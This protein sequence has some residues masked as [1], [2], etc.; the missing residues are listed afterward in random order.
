M[1]YFGNR[2]WHIS[3]TAGKR[4]VA[5]CYWKWCIVGLLVR[6][7]P[8]QMVYCWFV[9]KTNHFQMVYYFLARHRCQWCIIG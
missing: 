7:L 5:V 2:E 8:L 3:G 6:L 4:Q 1:L 9:S